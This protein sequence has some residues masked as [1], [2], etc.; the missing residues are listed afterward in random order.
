MAIA[1][2]TAARS[3]ITRAASSTLFRMC[4]RWTAEG[5][6]LAGCS[7]R[8]GLMMTATQAITAA[9]R[10]EAGEPAGDVT[11]PQAYLLV[12]NSACHLHR[13]A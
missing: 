12:Q 13:V 11:R 1:T 6:Q 9:T 3:S 10:C 8:P 5:L 2:R 4:N 7:V